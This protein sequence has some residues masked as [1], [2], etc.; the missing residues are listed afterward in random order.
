MPEDSLCRKVYMFATYHY[1]RARVSES[2]RRLEEL[3][4][5]PLL[6]HMDS[7][8]EGTRVGG[9]CSIHGT[10]HGRYPIV[11]NISP[12]T[13][14]RTT[15]KCIQGVEHGVLIGLNRAW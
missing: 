14:L 2:R 8:I 13:W 6:R 1:V 5:R 9:I 15:G 7:R 10:G 11:N 12:K 4:P 3:S